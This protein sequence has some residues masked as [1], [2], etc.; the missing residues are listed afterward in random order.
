MI[1]QLLACQAQNVCVVP[2][3]I[4]SVCPGPLIVRDSLVLIILKPWYLSSASLRFIMYSCIS[5][6]SSRWHSAE[7]AQNHEYRI[8]RKQK[9]LPIWYRSE[10]SKSFH[11]SARTASVL[12][13]ATNSSS[14]Q[15]QVTHTKQASNSGTYCQTIT[16]I[17]KH[18]QKEWNEMTVEEIKETVTHIND[19]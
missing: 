1:G 6:I 16:L 5:R 9:T 12:K 11:A 2:I 7:N 13:V 17:I 10:K 3:Y 15:Q 18:E 19:Q 14:P 4:E 8:N